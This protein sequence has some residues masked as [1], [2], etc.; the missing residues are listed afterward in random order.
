F[1][2]EA[3]KV[4]LMLGGGPSVPVQKDLI[5]SW[6]RQDWEENL[7]PGAANRRPREELLQHLEAMLELETSR[8]P[9]IALNGSLGQHVRYVLAGQRREARADVFIPPCA[10]TAPVAAWVAGTRAG[11]EG[12]VV[13]ETKD[14]TELSSLRVP[15]LY[16]WQGFHE[17]F[18]GQLE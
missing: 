12:E 17:L 13:F 18:L 2:Y 3:L 14:G 7:Y 16:T 15:N 10:R 4:Y 8:Q 9:T 11:P 6:M 1:L 5:M